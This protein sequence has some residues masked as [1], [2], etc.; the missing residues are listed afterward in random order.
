MKI[1]M[2]NKLWK[3]LGYHICEEFTD[4]QDV[5]CHL[6]LIVNGSKQP[7]YVSR[8]LK[9]RQCKVCYKEQTDAMVNIK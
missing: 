5:E 3:L 6:Q 2:L 8:R 7:S 9:I 4:W 1:K